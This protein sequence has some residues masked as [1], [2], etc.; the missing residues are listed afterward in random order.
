MK[1]TDW[2][3]VALFGFLVI[4]MQWAEMKAAGL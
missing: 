1:R 3:L 2:F 4:A